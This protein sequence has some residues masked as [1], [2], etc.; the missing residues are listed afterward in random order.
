MSYEKGMLFIDTFRQC[1][2]LAFMDAAGCTNE[3]C[4]QIIWESD[5][6]AVMRRAL[7]MFPKKM[8]V[9]WSNRF[10]SAIK[11]MIG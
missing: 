3:A 2:A 1:E 6:L 8:P 10:E 11:Q 4:L 5:D 7:R 9:W